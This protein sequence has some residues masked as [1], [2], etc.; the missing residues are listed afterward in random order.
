MGRD[1][2]IYSWG[3][4]GLSQNVLVGVR[5]QLI[6]LFSKKV[7]E[8]RVV[9]GQEVIRGKNSSRSGKSRRIFF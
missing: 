1:F 7:A 2:E 9:T 3:Q 5:R 8:I 6:F 4:T